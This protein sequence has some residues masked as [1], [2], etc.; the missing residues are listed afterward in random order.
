MTECVPSER[1]V[2]FAAG[3]AT[4]LRARLSEVAAHVRA[5]KFRRLPI[6]ASIPDVATQFADFRARYAALRCRGST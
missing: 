1:G 3:D 5:R 6:D 2:A 4:A